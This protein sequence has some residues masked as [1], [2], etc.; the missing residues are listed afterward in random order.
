MAASVALAA[1]LAAC[2][3]LSLL[4]STTAV[5]HMDKASDKVYEPTWESLGEDNIPVGITEREN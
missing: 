3:F 5:A 4:S 2:L 1:S